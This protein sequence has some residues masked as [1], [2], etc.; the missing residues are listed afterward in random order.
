MPV[1]TLKI[2]KVVFDTCR[3]CR[4]WARPT[5]KPIAPTR[6]ATELNQAVQWDILFYRDYMISLI[7]DEATRFCT[8]SVLPSKS[9]QDL[10]RSI[11][12]DWI[13]FFGAPNLIVADGEK[14]LDSEEAKQWLDRFHS[15]IKPKARGQHAQTVER[16]HE[17]LRQTLHRVEDQLKEESIHLPFD[18]VLAECMFVNNAM[19]TVGDATPYQAVFGRTPVMLP[20]FE[21]VS[22]SSL[23]DLS[24]GVA[25]FSRHDLRIREIALEKMIQ[26]SS[27]TRL[28]RG[29]NSKTRLALEQLDLNQG[30]LVDFWRKPA[31]KDESGWRGPA[32]VVEV[33]TPMVLRWHNGT[34]NVRL[35]DVRRSLVYLVL[36]TNRFM[37]DS[38]LDDPYDIL[39]TFADI[40]RG[41]LVRIEWIAPT[42]AIMRGDHRR[43]DR[44]GWPRWIRAKATS[45]HSMILN[46]VLLFAANG[47]GTGGCIGARIGQGLAKLE[48]AI[49]SVSTITLWWKIGSPK[50]VS[51]SEASEVD[52]ISWQ[53][54]AG[55][56]E[57]PSI[58]FVQ[59]L[60][61]DDA[62]YKWIKKHEPDVPF[63]DAPDPPRGKRPRGADGP[64]D[65]NDQ[66]P[67]KRPPP[68][69]PP[70]GAVA[71][72]MSDTPT[73][74]PS[75]STRS[76]IKASSS[77]SPAS[78]R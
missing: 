42:A 69:Q 21:L 35:Q 29:M 56:K 52:R 48:R 30:D 32:T 44:D 20:G 73:N 12:R 70:G 28:E 17:L 2:I 19:L 45:R 47:L 43:L 49:E 22:E 5:P 8:A 6:L 65:E 25:G 13:R 51:T 58:S 63:P 27:R 39:I 46:A 55:K 50:S 31:T 38:A 18:V 41:D 54:V 67:Y 59:F 16:H 72:D 1:A 11:S 64:D 14:G 66:P 78:Q 3:I 26:H 7:V 36:L 34:L 33:G 61:T 77:G 40:V 68:D 4:C 37:R 24:A 15:E 75:A 10:I 74:S 57:W 9:A 23:D 62:E 53:G 60:F 76:P 71:Q